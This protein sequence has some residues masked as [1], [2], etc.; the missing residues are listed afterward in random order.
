MVSAVPT[1]TSMRANS[2]PSSLSSLVSNGS[3]PGKESFGFSQFFLTQ[4][5]RM[6][7]N[8]RARNAFCQT[9][10]EVV[11]T[12]AAVGP[13]VDRFKLGER[14]VAET[15]IFCGDCFYCR[16]GTPLLCENFQANGITLNGG[17]A[18]YAAFKSKE[19]P[20]PPPPS[21]VEKVSLSHRSK[22]KVTF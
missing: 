20:L 4:Q 14:V 2:W 5:R 17:F 7:Y 1:C 6:L 13:K 22:T 15:T 21:Q 10:H 8:M 3:C 12:V 11:G 18:E 9:G 16:R 19:A